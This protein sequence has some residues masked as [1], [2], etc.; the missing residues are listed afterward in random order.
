MINCVE[1]HSEKY[2]KYYNFRCF[3]KK[4][5]QEKRK[6]SKTFF[7][8]FLLENSIIWIGCVISKDFFRSAMVKEDDLEAGRPEFQPETVLKSGLALLFLQDSK[9]LRRFMASTL[10]FFKTRGSLT[11]E[12]I[13]I[14]DS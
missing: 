8:Y 11:S 13:D 2:R 12:V 7:S 10:S 4:S 9:I 6:K 5:K 1:Q 3:S 14:G